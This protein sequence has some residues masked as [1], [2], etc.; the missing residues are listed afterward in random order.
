[1]IAILLCISAPT[2]A[3]TAIK[4]TAHFI[5]SMTLMTGEKV[6]IYPWSSLLMVSERSKVIVQWQI[7]KQK[8]R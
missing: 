3:A 1:M 7:E 6:K 8:P 2:A 5:H 4:W